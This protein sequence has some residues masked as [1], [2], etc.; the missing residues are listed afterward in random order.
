MKKWEVWV[1]TRTESMNKVITIIRDCDYMSFTSM[2]ENLLLTN[3]KI[4][5]NIVDRLYVHFCSHSSMAKIWLIQLR[6]YCRC[7]CSISWEGA[8][9]TW[10]CAHFLWDLEASCPQ[11]QQHEMRLKWYMN[12]VA[13][14]EKSSSSRLRAPGLIDPGLCCVAFFLS[15]YLY[16]IPFLQIMVT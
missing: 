14:L 12:G 10:V 15:S 7:P 9:G 6:Q 3:A 13:P 1:N 4:E 11:P 8:I 5:E 16:Q 2:L